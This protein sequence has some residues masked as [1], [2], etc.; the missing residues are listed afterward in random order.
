MQSQQT[1]K[2]TCPG[3][4]IGKKDESWSNPSNYATNPSPHYLA[5]PPPRLRIPRRRRVQK[6]AGG[7]LAP[8]QGRGK[9]GRG[10]VGAEVP[11]DVDAWSVCV[12]GDLMCVCECVY[13]YLCGWGGRVWVIVYYIMIVCMF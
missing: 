2:S 9:E 8:V 11:A 6:L 4:G 7:L 13:I 12:C 1:A 5:R 10:R 3:F